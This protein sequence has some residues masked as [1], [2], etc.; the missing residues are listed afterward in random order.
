M[1]ENE[2]VV[3]PGFHDEYN[4]GRLACGC[5]GRI[6]HD[7]L[8]CPGGEGLHLLEDVVE[9][10]IQRWLVNVWFNPDGE[11][12]DIRLRLDAALRSLDPTYC[13]LAWSR[14]PY[15][16]PFNDLLRQFV[17]GLTR[18]SQARPPD[19]AER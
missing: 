16:G 7:G 9:E 19:C 1:L 14:R 12:E 17:V 5:W 8:G 15:R 10:L 13:D 4:V 3:E 6:P 2:H 11:D 18:E